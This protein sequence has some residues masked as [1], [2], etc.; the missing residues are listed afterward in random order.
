MAKDKGSAIQKWDEELA[1]LAEQT[2]NMEASAGGGQFFSVK[3]GVLTFGDAPVPNNEM[4]VVI[5]DHILENVHYE[6]E[7]DADNRSSPTC[8]AFGRDEKEMTPH[9]AAVDAG[10]AEEGPCKSCEKNEFGSADRGK[11]KACK[12]TRRLAMVPAGTL[13]DNG[14]KITLIDDAEHYATTPV[15]FMKLPV[16]SVKGF[17]T[18]VKQV[19]D[20]MRVP[21][22]GLAT[23]V[24]V[25]P[26]AKTQHKV[27]FTPMAKLPNSLIPAVMK[28]REEVMATI[29][30]PYQAP[31]EDA[32]KK[33]KG[34]SGSRS[35]RY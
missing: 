14:R 25:V 30:F 13:K 8:Y 28:R 5:I 29:D 31:E 16:T 10:R 21:P 1:K 3:G 2:A 35:K 23:K 4:A 24:S 32:P 17:A 34:K 7:Y 9:Q 15:G 20:T 18:F 6:D 22:C 19:A 27:L 12:N 26:D 33:G 11:G